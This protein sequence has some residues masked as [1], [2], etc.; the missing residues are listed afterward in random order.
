MTPS[1]SGT[2]MCRHFS[3]MNMFEKW[4]EPRTCAAAK[5]AEKVPDA[6]F[7]HS[8]APLAFTAHQYAFTAY[9]RDPAAAPP[10]ADVPAARMR[11]Y[12]ELLYK[13]VEGSL[14]ACYPVLRSILG[15]AAWE[16]LVQCF[17]AQHRC[18][19]PI[20]REL[21]GEL[22]RWLTAAGDTLDLPPFA[23]EL[24]HYEWIELALTIDP[25]RI[26]DVAADPH[27]DLLAGIPVVSP[28]AHVLDYAFPVH[29]LSPD[30][31]PTDAPAART[32]LA[33]YRDR[34][35]DVRFMELN[36]LTALLLQQ[37][38]DQTRPGVQ[39]LDAIAH[40]NPKLD[41]AT[42][43]AGGAAILADLRERD[44]ILGTLLPHKR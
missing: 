29:R 16:A 7:Q 12:R 1:P 14:S 31:A 43:Q 15:D 24:A 11:V 41:A 42:V 10:P 40:A 33:V 19:T 8:I 44:V 39:V 2:G 4:S 26:E 17:F 32:H 30:Q 3:N 6:L 37:L 20:Y 36:P 23:R 18:H 25:A 28:L 38:R 9:V 35:D 34:R 21:P 22:L 27:G 13:N 5:R